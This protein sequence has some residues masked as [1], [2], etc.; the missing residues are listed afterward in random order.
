MR[1]GYTNTIRIFLCPIMEH[2]LYY[3]NLVIACGCTHLKDHC[4]ALLFQNP[5]HVFEFL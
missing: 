2:L 4:H 1:D 3:Q 5:L